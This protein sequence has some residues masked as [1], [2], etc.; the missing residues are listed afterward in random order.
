MFSTAIYASETWKASASIKNKLDVFQQCY[1]RRTLKI[2]YTN[3]ITNEEVLRWSGAVKLHNI[4][5]HQRLQMA[6]C[7]KWTA[8]GYRCTGNL[9]APKS[10]PDVHEIPGEGRSFKT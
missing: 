1:L 4:I 3:H 8:N 6:T 5:A 2:C 7:S 10:L 9:K